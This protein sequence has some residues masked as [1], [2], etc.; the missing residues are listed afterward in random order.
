MHLKKKIVRRPNHLVLGDAAQSSDPGI[1]VCKLLASRDAS[2]SGEYVLK[3]LH[4]PYALAGVEIAAEL[5]ISALQKQERILIVGDFDADGATSTAL[6]MKGLCLFGFEN[7]RYLVP[8]RFEYGYGL[9]PEIVA[10]ASESKP[11]L[12]I[13]VDNGISSIDGVNEAKRRNIKVIVT[14]HHLPGKL[15]PDADAIV[16]PNQPGCAFPS[17]NLAGVGVA[18]YLLMVLRSELRKLAWFA[19]RS[20][21]EPNIAQFLDL[22]ALGTVADV[23]ALDGNNRIL[24]A[25]GIQRIRVG[26]CCA[27]IQAL[28]KV[29]NRLPERLVADDFGFAVGPRLNAAGRIDDMS[30]GIQCLLSEHFNEALTIAGELDDLNQQRKAIE[31]SMQAEAIKDL[32]N[33][34]NDTNGVLRNGIC[35]FREDWHQGV[36]G[37]IASRI[38]DRM[39]RPTIAFSRAGASELKGSG[40]SI[41]GIHLRDVLDTIATQK[42]A[43]LKKFG[44][45]AMAAGLSLQEHAFEEFSHVFDVTVANLLEA[46]LREPIVYSDGELNAVN[47]TLALAQAI[48]DAGPWGQSFP[49]PNFDG[50]FRI[51]SQ[52][53]VG[54]NHLKMLLCPSEFNDLLVDAIAF[55]VSEEQWP[56]PDLRSIRL[57]Y[58]LDV[59]E[60]RNKQSLQLIVNYLEPCADRC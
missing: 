50:V 55:N 34:D 49:E 32:S 38:K 15:L 35:L 36:V 48:R 14:D 26:K 4:D 25:Q 41:P 51:I 23:V 3:N 30:I 27:G 54:T 18:F 19:S 58:K 43:L 6:L 31:S 45:H 5:L 11:H 17:K 40:R 7:I 10:L 42:P 39:H 60:F 56:A 1:L 37:I 46:D 53:R 24:V 29:A 20:I 8:N 22:V 16:N 2:F 57:V 52:K 59:N 21:E 28:L 12:I 33:I 44:G 9:T 13:T 47:M